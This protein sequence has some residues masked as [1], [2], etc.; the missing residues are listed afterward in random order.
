MA[1]WMKPWGQV[2]YFRATEIALLIC[3][4][5]P[6]EPLSWAEGSVH[7]RVYRRITSDFR[8]AKRIIQSS[9]E[10]DKKLG[11]STLL[12]TLTSV[13]LESLMREDAASNRD[14]DFALLKIQDQIFTRES[15]CAWLSANSFE[16]QVPF[17]V[18]ERSKAAAS[19]ARRNLITSKIS[20]STSQALR[21]I[22]KRDQ[23]IGELK[24][25]VAT[26][27]LKLTQKIEA[28][29]A[30]K[31][32]PAAKA[33]SEKAIETRERNSVSAIIF[34]LATELKIDMNHLKKASDVIERIT[35]IHGVRVGTK[36]IQPW[37]NGIQDAKASKAK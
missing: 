22:E 27:K 37:L 14:L 28:P 1:E 24:V 29:P 12:G 6:S 13:H 18:D 17:E 23:L 30:N 2:S 32:P 19:R 31:R 8:R 16:S 26:L 33:F 15:I 36:T 3:G 20:V 4:L 34:A 9:I 11:S 10:D 21:E 35:E 25:E 7:T 5:N